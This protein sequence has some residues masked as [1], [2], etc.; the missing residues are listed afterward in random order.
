MADGAERQRTRALT[1]F[2]IMSGHDRFAVQVREAP[3]GLEV[4]I[5]GRVHRVELLRWVEP[6]HF[7][8][9]IDGASRPVEIVRAGDELRVRIGYEQYRLQVTPR[10]SIPRRGTAGRSSSADVRIVAPMPG[11]IVAVQVGPGSH[12][13]QGAVVVI[14]EAMKMQME[15]RAPRSGQISVISVKPGE[16][17]AKGQILATLKTQ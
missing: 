1:D 14:M 11:L 5:D 13:E 10:I 7:V 2:E 12:V 3:G 9:A 8:L 15:I 6:T 4:S 17:V 16:E